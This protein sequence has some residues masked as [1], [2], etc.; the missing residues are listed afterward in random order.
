MKEFSLL[1]MHL[2]DTIRKVRK[3]EDKMFEKALI[4]LSN[5]PITK[6]FVGAFI[7]LLLSN[8]AFINGEYIGR[9]ISAILH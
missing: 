8:L 7:T 4:I 3:S 6:L 1:F 9:F 2:M 5:Y